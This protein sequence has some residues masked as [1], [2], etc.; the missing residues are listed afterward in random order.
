[1]KSKSAKKRKPPNSRS[2]QIDPS[3]DYDRPGKI[4]KVKSNGSSE[5]VVQA[6]SLTNPWEPDGSITPSHEDIVRSFLGSYSREPFQRQLAKFLH[7]APDRDSIK[8]FAKRNPD[9]WA[10]AVETFANLS[11]YTQKLEIDPASF[12][13]VSMMSDS[14][15]EQRLAQLEGLLAG[16]PTIETKSIEQQ[17]SEKE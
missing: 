16:K 15:I 13:A 9:K 8:A 12:A 3:I 6:D 14:Q 17:K 5:L 4:P 7:C 1:M 2:K 10:K 11:G